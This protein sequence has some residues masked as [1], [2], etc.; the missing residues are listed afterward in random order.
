MD[1]YKYEHDSPA[2]AASRDYLRLSS[3][4]GNNKQT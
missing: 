2:P 3:S 1:K 4:H